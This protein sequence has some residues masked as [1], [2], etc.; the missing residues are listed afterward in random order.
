MNLIYNLDE[1]RLATISILF[2]SLSKSTQSLLILSL[3]QYHF[4]IIP[5][6]DVRARKST[7]SEEAAEVEP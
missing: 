3:Y 2:I 4:L 7:L 6:K 1:N 5:I